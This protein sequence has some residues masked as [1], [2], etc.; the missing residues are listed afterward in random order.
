MAEITPYQT[1]GPFFHYGLM[2]PGQDVVAPDG[3][4]GRRIQV[5][6]RVLDGE[7]EPMI[8]AMVEIWQ[9]DAE[10]RYAHPLDPRAPAPRPGAN[11][12]FTGFGRI[13]TDETGTWRATTIMPGPV[14]HPGGGMQAP[15]LN[16]G[17]F[18][19]GVLTRLHTRLY[20]EGEP[21]N[22]A[23]P[24]LALVDPDRRDTLVARRVERDGAVAYVLDIRVQG[25][26]ETVFFLA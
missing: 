18:A 4:P 2:R 20:F 7:G 11:L 26:G 24:V 1:V 3:V 5:G 23:D 19:R 13:A 22:A 25:E 6:G 17:V 8:D 9:A 15:H 16:L 10:G 14:P 12:A 21:A